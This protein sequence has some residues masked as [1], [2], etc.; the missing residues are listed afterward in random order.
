MPTVTA[1]DGLALYA[2]VHATEAA[3]EGRAQGTGP[4]QPSGQARP[5]SG[6]LRA[7]RGRAAFGR[8]E[9]RSS[10]VVL[11][12]G[13]CQTHENFRP[14]VAPLQAAG[15]RVVLWDYRGH[16]R[17]DAPEDPARYSI[18][19]VEADLGCVLDATA[20]GRRVVLGGLSFGGLASLRFTLAHPER[21]SA[22]LLLA[23]GPGFKKPEAQQRWEAQVERIATR[24]EERGAG[25][26]VQ[27]RAAETGIG[28]R[29]DLPA[30][31]AAARAITAQNGRALACFGRRVTGPVPSLIDALPRIDV[32]ALVVV[33]AEDEA[34]LRAGEVMAARLPNAKHLVIRGAGHVVNIEE[35][36]ALN[37]AL[38]EFLATLPPERG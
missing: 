11:S 14:Q 10:T 38:I 33:G 9:E 27:G 21:V 35:A 36:E 20:P 15:H 2:E 32:P 37:A 6:G 26:L 30:A 34:Y 23:S 3:P 7:Q 29:P 16:G 28:R 13:F 19:Q 5:A 24:L 12:P 22:L 18:E 8:P 4:K 17:S 31:Q 1:S 25:S